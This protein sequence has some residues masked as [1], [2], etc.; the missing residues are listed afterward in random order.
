MHN[1]QHPPRRIARL[2]S[3]R[4]LLLSFSAGAASVFAFA[5]FHFVPI[6]LVSLPILAWQLDGVNS[7]ETA[8]WRIQAKRAAAI[9]WAFA[10]G[11]HGVGIHWIGHAFLV[12]TQRH[13]FLL[14]L[15][16]LFVLLVLPLFSVAACTLARL[17]LWHGNFGRIAALAALL[18]LADWIR[19]HI[20]TGFPWNLWGNALGGAL[21]W[22]QSAS[23]LG[24]YGLCLAVL[25][26]A[27]I[28]AMLLRG[29]DAP[30][31]PGLRLWAA[32][33]LLLL[34]AGVAWLWGAQRMQ[35]QEEATESPAIRLVQPN[36][37]Q[38]EKQRRDRRNE[39][40]D[41]LL[42]LSF[43]P[44][45]ENRSAPDLIIWPEV[46]LLAHLEEET[47]LRAHIAALMPTGARLLTGSLRREMQGGI[48]QRYNSLL[49]FN[50]R[51]ELEAVYDKRHLVPFG[52]Y[53]PYRQRIDTIAR[54]LGMGLEIRALAALGFTAGTKTRLLSLGE[55]PDVGALICYEVIFSGS[56]L[57][58]EGRPQW[59]VNISNDAWFGNS[60]GPWQHLDQ[61]RLRAIEEGLPLLRATNTGIS[62]VIDS[63]GRITAM[64]APNRRGI[65]DVR[66]PP[67][68]PPTLFS[69]W[70]DAPALLLAGILILLAGWGRLTPQ[71]KPK[72]GNP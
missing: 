57:P 10:A 35:V 37:D 30:S 67:P 59:L 26:T 64:L 44:D 29:D 62:A 12:D 34:L 17:C 69:R 51:D 32:P 65:L 25:L 13:A 68:A 52:E 40:A 2:R 60:I 70:G 7:S 53:I 4:A 47:V 22:A 49:V 42:R 46:A 31:R 27:L 66:L 39:M 61:A 56:I 16:A 23:V 72:V 19:G 15:P 28:P 54:A 50:S 71:L 9:S 14:P 48:W 38:R 24:V 6:L 8:H 11:F 5:P 21:P 36:F 3:W 18:T 45:E 58:E 20:F 33:M 1:L 41:I 55:L 63:R 43:F